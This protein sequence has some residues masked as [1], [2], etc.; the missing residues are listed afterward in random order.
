MADWKNPLI[1]FIWIISGL[2]ILLILLWFL[3]IFV[4]R[5]VESVRIS[6][7]EKT[8]LELNYQKEL[9]LHSV[10]VQEKERTRIAFE[11]HDDLISQLHRIKILNN[12][13]RLNS[14]LRE[15]ISSARRISHDLTPPLLSEL[16][17]NELIFDFLEPLKKTYTINVN[18]SE[19]CNCR[20][21]SVI[22][23]H[24][25]RIFQELINNIVKHSEA[26]TIYSNLRVSSK[27]VAL[28]VCDDGKGFKSSQVTGLGLKNIEL[29][30]QL[31]NGVYRFRK[32]KKKGTNFL[33]ALNR[34][35][36][37]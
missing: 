26:E 32:G 13:T 16:T 31:V 14:L 19:G 5:Y 22:K 25:F 2:V 8:N 36:N 7:Q 21:G 1:L 3:F 27:Y 9:L 29:R 4:R 12:D 18:A 17:L 24:L 15:S 34:K 10:D 28:L 20:L 33:I 6:E 35:V 30:A 11:L 37:E 23:L